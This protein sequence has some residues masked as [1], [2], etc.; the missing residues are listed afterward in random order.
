[1]FD[2]TCLIT[3]FHTYNFAYTHMHSTTR[4]HVS[5]RH[6]R[7]TAKFKSLWKPHGRFPDTL[8]ALNSASTY[9]QILPG[10]T[11]VFQCALRLSKNIL[12]CSWKHLQLWTCIR[13]GVRLSIWIVK[14]W[15]SWNPCAGL[16]DMPAAAETW[17]PGL[18][19]TW[20]QI[21]TALC[22]RVPQ[23]QH[24]MFIVLVSLTIA[25]FVTSQDGMYDWCLCRN[26][27]GDTGNTAMDRVTGRTYLGDSGVDWHHIMIHSTLH[28]FGSHALLPSFIA[29]GNEC[30]ST[31]TLAKRS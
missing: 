29:A 27:Y 24:N 14:C 28:S 16:Q 17:V 1:M 25:R 18:R 9:F 31:H 6:L 10:T 23:P 15:S 12:W 20:H 11:R 19:K 30:D 3:R 4:A 7:I 22:L 2:A 21:L 13:N 8:V 5:A 26:T